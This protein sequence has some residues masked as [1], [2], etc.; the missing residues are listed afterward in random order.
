MRPRTRRGVIKSSCTPGFNKFLNHNKGWKLKPS[1][2][3]NKVQSTTQ[4]WYAKCNKKI[5][6]CPCSFSSLWPLWQTNYQRNHTCKNE[7]ART[8]SI[9][10]LNLIG[11]TTV[12]LSACQK[13]NYFI[14]L[15][16]RDASLS[17]KLKW[18]K[19]RPKCQ[20]CQGSVTKLKIWNTIESKTANKIFPIL[21]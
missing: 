9:E 13:Q 8:M 2:H 7:V 3:P 21:N 1:N 19:Y 20:S 6:L 10:S 18:T 12:T 17:N 14:I 5:P 4:E 16:L 15:T 11:Y